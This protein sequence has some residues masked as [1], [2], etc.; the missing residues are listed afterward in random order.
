MRSAGHD[1]I[2]FAAGE[3]D[4]QTPD[5]ILDAA[6][7]AMRSGFT[8]YTAGN[9]IR[10][11]R[12]AV[13]E[14]FWRVNEIRT[15][16]GDV[17][18]TCGAKHALANAVLGLVDP[19]DEV[20]I[21]APYWMSYSEQVRVAGGIPRL[22]YCRAEDDF[23]PRIET[24]EDAVTPRTKA[25][26][27]CSPNNPTGAVWPREVFAQIADVAV[28]TGSWLISDEVY[29]SL[30]Y[31]GEHVSPAALDPAVAAQTITIGSCSK[32]YA[33]TGW[34]LGYMTGPPSAMKA[35]ACV[36][37]TI[38]HPTSFV[39]KAALAAFAM[40][41]GSMDAMREEY[42]ARRDLMHGLVSSIPGLS[43][44]LPRGAF[45][46]MGDF[47]PYLGDRFGNDQALAEHLL[48]EAHVAVI[49]GTVFAMPSYL[50]FSYAASRQNIERG[51]ARVAEALQKLPV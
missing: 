25:I 1:V 51:V 50:R 38:S 6:Y 44:R 20:V 45:Y 48:E 34:R 43:P 30:I 9:G 11:L 10:E 8:K 12:E 32:T 16:A 13:A 3:P 23:V 21:V 28:R 19:G 47:S 49:P 24:I 26:M 29:E 36:Q 17:L 27:V 18:V 33:M 31:E 14:K 22:A 35:M 40:D 4:F 46:V 2:S 41:D 42:R 37:D 15:T 7:E 5:P 39:Q